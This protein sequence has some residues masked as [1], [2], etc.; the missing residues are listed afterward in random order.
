MQHQ[1]LIYE[2]KPFTISSFDYGYKDKKNKLSLIEN[3]RTDKNAVKQTGSEMWCFL[4][5]LS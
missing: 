1:A 5:F 4:F 3:L 2:N